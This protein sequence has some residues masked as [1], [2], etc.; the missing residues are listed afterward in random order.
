MPRY[1]YECIQC[2]EASTISHLSGEVILDC[3]SCLKEGS[4]KKLLTTFTS[5]GKKQGV[6]KEVGEVTEEFIETS[7]T[8]L[9]KQKQEL[10]NI[11]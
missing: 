9:H 1:Q 3:P 7:R 8:E 5:P 2:Q 11:K 10:K 4:M 6:R